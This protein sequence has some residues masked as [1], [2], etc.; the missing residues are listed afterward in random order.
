MIQFV[1]N[2]RRVFAA[3]AA[4]V[5]LSVLIPALARAQAEPTP[6]SPAPD[7]TTVQPAAVGKPAKK[8][9]APKTPKTPESAKSKPAAMTA[10]TDSASDSAAA[11]PGKPAKAPRI[12]APEKS[13]EEQKKEDGVYAKGSN[14]ISLR[15]GYAKRTGDLNGDGL[16]GYGVGYQ[17]M[18]DNRYAF[19]AGAG[20]DIVGHFAGRLDEAVPFTA[21]FQRHFNWKS[22]V[23][24]FVGVGGGFYFRKAY[25]TGIDYTTTTTGGPHLSIGFTSALD[26]A[27]A[28]GFETRIARIQ[29]RP[30]VVN[31]TFGPGEVTE[32][33][34]TAKISWALVY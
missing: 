15:F 18:I 7:T 24:P 8:G 12:R 26:D 14:W 30:G 16:V 9:K 3:V 5:S 10:A 34:W 1:A 2:L 13:R 33:I 22:S 4:V 6:E 17:H 28:I 20:H 21:E 25:R 31:T 29:G 23:R 19:A 32:T 11:K 27:H